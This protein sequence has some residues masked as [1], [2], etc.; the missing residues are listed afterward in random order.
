MT[1]EPAIDRT[2]ITG[3]VRQAV[4]SRPLAV[5]R[6]QCDAIPGGGGQ[7]TDGVYRVSG[8]AFDQ[9][10]MVPW[11][12][13]LKVVRSRDGDDPSL[14]SY[15]RREV[16]AYA[17]GMLD[18]LPPGLAAPRCL[19]VHAQSSGATWLWL[20][21]IVDASPAAWSR[22]EFGRAA[23]HLGAFNGA[24]LAGQIL[25]AYPW[26][27]TRWLHSWVHAAAPQVALLPTV[28]DHPLV[29][30]LFA[31]DN[32]QRVQDLWADCELLLGAL[33]GLPQTL[34]HFDAI[35]RNLFAR[36]AGDR[37]G[38]TIA[39]DWASVGIGAIGADLGP[40]VVGSVLLYGADLSCLRDL[41]RL[42]F[43]SYLGGLEEAGWRGDTRLARLGYTA[44]SALRYSLYSVVRMP[45][46][47]DERHVAW[48]ERVVGHPIAD[49]IDRVV[50]I[51]D[52]ALA[53][54]DEARRL[55]PILS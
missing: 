2:T 26:L 52:Y 55:L 31:A 12:L 29:G 37:D 16:D 17:S 8:T 27:S 36:R 20:E 21:H 44:S 14:W 15:G 32:P 34:C 48:A 47:L 42:A 51:R 5:T 45:V 4:R 11:S 53:Q 49:Y 33:D 24:Y 19:G 25:P 10:L 41:D 46:L 6:W 54:A 1:A 3:V 35:R 18:N 7:A 30:R 50:A 13:I 43:A 23:Y 39:I 22:H 40:L 28:L 9:G 38:E